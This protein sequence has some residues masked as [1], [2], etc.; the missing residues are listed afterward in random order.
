MSIKVKS[1]NFMLTT[2]SFNII[3]NDSAY[4]GAIL[5][6]NA[7]NNH[8]NANSAL[9]PLLYLIYKEM[10]TIRPLLLCRFLYTTMILIKLP[11]T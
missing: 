5:H 10:T 3:M 11:V 8:R 4:F 1:F 2:L 9:L 7:L 6:R